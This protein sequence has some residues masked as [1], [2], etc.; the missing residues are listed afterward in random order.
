MRPELL[1]LVGKDDNKSKLG[2][3]LSGMVFKNSN[4]PSP[5]DP[6][7]AVAPTTKPGERPGTASGQAGAAPPAFD[8]RFMSNAQI[9]AKLLPREYFAPYLPELNEWFVMYREMMEGWLSRLVDEV[10][11]KMK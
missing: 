4:T 8:D 2:N 10:L 1:E 11:K 7:K 3:M 5:A 9:V 6:S